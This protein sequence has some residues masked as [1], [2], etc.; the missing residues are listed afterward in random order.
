M[1]AKDG[2]LDALVTG[3]NK[4]MQEVASDVLSGRVPD[5][6]KYGL[7]VGQFN[8]LKEARDIVAAAHKQWMR[9]DKDGD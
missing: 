3:L 7:L 6:Y 4:Q 2:L 5:L 9:E 8:G 1:S